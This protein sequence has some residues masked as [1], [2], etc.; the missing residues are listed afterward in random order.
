[1][2]LVD[3]EPDIRL[4]IG[5]RLEADGF[6]V[7][8]ANDGEEALLQAG[9]NPDVIVLDLMLPKR[10]GL[11]VCQTLR[12]EHRYNTIPIVFFTSKDHDDVLG[13]LS[14]DSELK[15]WGA[16]AFVSKSAGVAELIRTIRR[17]LA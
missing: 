5:K 1:M 15:Q 4:I 3:D 7:F 13:R 12:Q 17:V 10:S 9:Q 16:Q 2:L 11:D 6:E 8:L 14:L